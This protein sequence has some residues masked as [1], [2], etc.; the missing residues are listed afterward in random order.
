VNIYD[1]IKR[2][3]T[4]KR[5]TQYRKS[6]L[7]IPCGWFGFDYKEIHKRASENNCHF[8]TYDFKEVDRSEKIYLDYCK[9]KEITYRGVNLYESSIYNICNDLE[10]APKFLDFSDQVQKKVLEKWYEIAARHVDYATRLF[11]ENKIEL[12]I[13]PQGYVLEAAVVRQIAVNRGVSVLAIENSLSKDK[14]LWDNVSG[15]TVNAN[16][17]KNYFWKFKSSIDE[18]TAIKYKEDFLRNIK[19]L[20][21]SEHSSPKTQYPR[22][23]GRKTILFLSQVYLDS[24][25]I[26]GIYDFPDTV[27]II[28][29]LCRF[30]ERMN[31]ELIVKLHPKEIEGNS[32]LNRPYDKITWRKIKSNKYLADKIEQQTYV[33]VDFENSYDTYSL[34]SNADVCV[35]VNSMAGI[36][37]LLLGKNV[38]LC[39]QSSYGGLGFT[40]EAYNQEFLDFFLELVTTKN[41]TMIN[42][43][44]DKFFYIYLE[45]YCIDKTNGALISLIEKQQLARR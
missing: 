22:N 1:E 14:L 29:I 21:V 42:A 37:A 25:I 18:R 30:C 43:D 40:F 10:L 15:I 44:A 11:D 39:G 41:K 35:T 36:E 20:K 7:I 12:V 26:F 6:C 38:I 45:K 16:L 3:I 27:K 8:I 17:G 31:Y 34:I 33:H 24:S 4:G 13:I 5:A 23:G 19:L 32:I 28:E 2:K 9:Y